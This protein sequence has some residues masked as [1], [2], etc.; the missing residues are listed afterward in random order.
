MSNIIFLLSSVFLFPIYLLSQPIVISLGSDCQGTV[1]KREYQLRE[2]AYPFDLV[3]TEDFES[4]IH[5]ISDECKNWLTP[6]YLEYRDNNI[7]NTLYRISFVHDFPFVDNHYKTSE[8]DYTSSGIIEP[9][10]KSYLSAAAKKY[11][12]R[13][14]RFFEVLNSTNPVIFIRTNTTPTAARRFVEMMKQKYPNLPFILVVVCTSKL[15]NMN[16]NIER[17]KNFYAVDKDLSFPWWWGH[18]TWQMVFKEM[19]LIQ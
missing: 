3:V 10:Y 13:I 19:G 4:V 1:Y 6:A 18:K 12:R 8:S 16:W 15:V 2:A 9:E 7:L 14:G 11:R 5:A 17:V